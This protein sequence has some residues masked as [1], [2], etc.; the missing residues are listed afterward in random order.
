MS[1]EEQIEILDLLTVLKAETRPIEGH[2][3]PGA[4]QDC[5]SDVFLKLVSYFSSR[6]LRQVI[7]EKKATA[8]EKEYEASDAEAFGILIA[9]HFNWDGEQIFQTMFNAFEDANFH[10]FN[11][12]LK[13]MW[14]KETND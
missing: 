4:I 12:Q 10:T 11:K 14:E 6:P 8:F 1:H 13:E 3:D 9:Q 5:W 7:E 2:T